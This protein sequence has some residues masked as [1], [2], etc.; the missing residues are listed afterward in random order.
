MMIKVPVISYF[1]ITFDV[2]GLTAVINGDADSDH[3]LLTEWSGYM[4]V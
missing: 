4:N 2:E 3:E 1:K